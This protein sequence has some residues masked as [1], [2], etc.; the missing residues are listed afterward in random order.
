MGISESTATRLHGLND[1]GTT[2]FLSR[3]KAAKG[4]SASYQKT[5]FASGDRV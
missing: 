3:P 5:S 2:L 1:R 4:T